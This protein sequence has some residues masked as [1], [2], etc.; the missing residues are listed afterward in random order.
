MLLLLLVLLMLLFS[1]RTDGVPGGFSWSIRESPW[2]L[3]FGSSVKA[4]SFYP[5][6]VAV[7]RT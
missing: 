6:S 2:S 7:V 5:I 1:K 3:C 4:Y